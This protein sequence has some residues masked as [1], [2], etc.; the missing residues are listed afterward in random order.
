MFKFQP[1]LST[2]VTLL[3]HRAF[4]D[5]TDLKCNHT[6]FEWALIRSKEEEA[7]KEGSH[8][9]RESGIGVKQLGDK[10]TKAYQQ[11]SETKKWPRSDFAPAPLGENVLC[12]CLTFKFLVSTT[13]R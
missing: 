10:G 3:G 8:K 7:Q 2:N 6:L 1:L 13:I 5:I 9:K 4:A 12:K 11:M